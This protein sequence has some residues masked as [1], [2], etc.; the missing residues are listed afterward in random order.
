MGLKGAKKISCRFGLIM[1][2][3]VLLHSSCQT[4]QQQTNTP[5]EQEAIELDP[6]AWLSSQLRFAQDQID[7]QRPEMALHTLRPLLQKDPNNPE[8]NNMM[9]V[10]QLALDN[11]KS[12][13]S[14]FTKAYKTKDDVSYGL[15][16]SAALIAQKQFAKARS[17]L[18]TLMRRK[19]YGFP[20]RLLHNIALTFE[21][22]QNL[23]KSIAY[24]KAALQQNPV[25]YLSI[26]RLARIYRQQN[27]LH[28]AQKTYEKAI[29]SCST[30][31]ESVKE[32]ALLHLKNNKRSQAQG[33]VERYLKIPEVHPADK[34]KAQNLL[35]LAQ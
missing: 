26:L 34:T 32:L 33:L 15:N 2:L 12:A 14:Y 20:E 24:Y 5:P 18:F 10:T 3:L 21:E 17:L 13:M 28:D 29:Y 7:Q 1:G 31:Y 23:G 22:E 16:L 9:G 11:S 6:E 19:D 4:L 8:L 35:Q 30:C 27:R 25:Y